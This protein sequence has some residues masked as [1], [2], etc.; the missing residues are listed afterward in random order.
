M[1]WRAPA[2]RP[3]KRKSASEIPRR[4]ELWTGPA[5]MLSIAGG[6]LT[7]YR[8]MAE[9]V[10]DEAA[11][12]LGRKP[13]PARPGKA[14]L[15]GGDVDPDGAPPHLRSDGL[16]ENAA[17]RLVD[18]YMAPRKR[19][20]SASPARRSKRRRRTRVLAEGALTLED[21]L[22]VRRSARAWFDLD[23]G[24]AALAP[25][26][27]AMAACCSAGRPPA[28]TPRSAA[29]PGAMVTTWRRFARRSAPPKAAHEHA[30]RGSFLSACNWRGKGSRPAKPSWTRG[31]TTTG[32]PVNIRDLAGNPSAKTGAA[33]RPVLGA[34]RPAD[35]R[36]RPRTQRAG[37]PLRPGE[38]RSGV[39]D[40]RPWGH[41]SRRGGDE[42]DPLHRRDHPAGGLRGRQ[43]RAGSRGGRRREGPSP[44]AIGRSRWRRAASAAGSPI[45]APLGSSPP[46]TATSR[47]SFTPSRAVTPDGQL[48]KLGRAAGLGRSADL[49]HLML[50]SEGTLGVITAVTLSLRRA[51]QSRALAAFSAP[52]VEAGFA[53]QREVIQSGWRPPVVRQY[54]ERE[55]RWLE[56]TAFHLASF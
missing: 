2:G 9:R 11:K 40:R 33:Q 8:Q 52:D 10:V 44:P 4:D 26:V 45:R 42:P 24:I 18:L 6:K 53:F 15:I 5:G 14:P 29:A 38:R 37:H 31:V 20:P 46:P 47:T 30:P 41:R 50:G 32:P 49:R 23:G 3:R 27:A 16:G 25:A 19:R 54:D 34:G 36:H 51:P 1:V 56:A 7:A 39:G 12:A 35:P 48:V 43:E 22:R 13:T 17:D 55:A 28:R 21:W